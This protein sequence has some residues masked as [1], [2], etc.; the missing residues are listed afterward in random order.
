MNN[1]SSSSIIS[2]DKVVGYLITDII[3][4][5]DGK[6]LRD[7]ENPP[8]DPYDLTG[9]TLD[10]VVYIKEAKDLPSLY[11]KDIQVEYECFYDKCIYKTKI[12]SAKSRNHVF[13]EYFV[14]KINYIQK[15]DIDYLLNENVYN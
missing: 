7:N 2:R 10:F 4:I 15:E 14:H 6:P 11:C 8:E 12:L 3:P 1:E 13:N 9:N 5:E